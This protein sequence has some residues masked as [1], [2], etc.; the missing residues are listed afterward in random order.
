MIHALSKLIYC[1]YFSDKNIFVS[2]LVEIMDQNLLHK[3]TEDESQKTAFYITIFL[4]VLG[5]CTGGL[6]MIYQMM[7]MF[8][9]PLIFGALFGTVLFPL[10]KAAAK[11]LNDWLNELDKENKPFLIGVALL[12]VQFLN[13]T[14]NSIFNGIRS[15]QG[16]ICISGYVL[17]KVLK[18]KGT[19]VALLSL[20]GRIYEGADLVLEF[21]TQTWIIP[22]TCLYAVAYIAWIYVQ[23]GEELRARKKFIRTLSI[24]FWIVLLAHIS[25]LFG[26]FRVF[27][28]TASS[29]LLGLIAAGIIGKFD[30]PTENEEEVPSVETEQNPVEAVSEASEERPLLPEIQNLEQITSNRMVRIAATL[31]GLSWTVDHDLILVILLVLFLHGFILNVA[32][33]L[34]LWD[35]ILSLLSN[36]LP[37]KGQIEK[38]TN[39]VVPGFLR[40]FVYILFTSD[41]YLIGSLKKKVDFIASVSTMIFLIFGVIIFGLFSAFQL[42]SEVVHVV[43]L[44]SNVVSS[45]KE[46]FANAMNYTGQKLNEES[47]NDYAEKT[48]N[49]SRGWLSSNIRSLADP[50]DKA[51]ADQLEEQAKILVDNLYRLYTE[52]IKNLPENTTEIANRDFFTQLMSA[53]NIESLKNEFTQIVKENL[54]T[55]LNI[56]KSLWGVLAANIAVLS[57]FLFSIASFLLGFG[58]IFLNFFIILIVFLTVAFYLLVN[59]TG[60]FLPIRWIE[61]FAP[62]IQARNS[63]IKIGH[64]VENAISSV[65]ILTAKMSIFYFLYTYFVHSLFGLTIVFIPSVLSSIFASVPL[66]PTYSV[67]IFGLIELYLIKEETFAALVFLIANFTPLFT[68]DGAFY[69]EIKHCHPY[70]IGLSIVGGI[71]SMGIEGAVIGPIILCILIVLFNVYAEFARR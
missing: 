16:I 71:Y 69:S 60:T 12:P 42:Q 50:K 22:L 8:L 29:I 65:F 25:S 35:A 20:L 49:Y 56:A 26:P 3:I 70:L 38:I 57:A 24:P 9:T 61:D 1:S 47:L 27:V 52:N 28:F 58:F 54:E 55:I 7:H 36:A 37:A 68:V 51:R 6:Y 31:F 19:F 30:D 66:V 17:L 10:K 34:Q 64:A 2:S 40:Q 33:K 14:S 32:E 11:S 53:T 18:Y 5:V 43:N 62:S 45:N 23:D 13:N 59:S 15:K 46:L 44:G 39:V 63:H 4:A 67:S 21:L 48:Y 41:R